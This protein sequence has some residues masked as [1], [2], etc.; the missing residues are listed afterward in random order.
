MLFLWIELKLCKHFWFKYKSKIL[1][2]I[3]SLK[4]II[5]F[6]LPMEEFQILFFFLFFLLSH[7]LKLFSF[8]HFFGIFLFQFTLFTFILFNFYISFPFDSL[9]S[10]S[11]FFNFSFFSNVFFSLL[12]YPNLRPWKK[13]GK[14]SL[15]L[16]FFFHNHQTCDCLGILALQQLVLNEQNVALMMIFFF[17]MERGNPKNKMVWSNERLGGIME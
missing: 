17:I 7:F 10:Y 4:F 12:K 13:E 5:P 11:F 6:T 9:L 15:W 16:L 1:S 3:F 8:V 2:Y 14:T